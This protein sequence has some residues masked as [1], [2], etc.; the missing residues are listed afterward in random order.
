[1]TIGDF[2][3]LIQKTFGIGYFSTF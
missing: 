3:Q 2:E 1:V